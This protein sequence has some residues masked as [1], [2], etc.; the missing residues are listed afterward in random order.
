MSA[1]QAKPS[2]PIKDVFAIPELLEMILGF[3][4]MRELH[5]AQKVCKKFHDTIRASHLLQAAL[6]IEPKR[7]SHQGG[8]KFCQAIVPLRCTGMS[9]GTMDNHSKEPG[10]F[11]S[12]IYISV[13]P[14]QIPTTI[15]TR[16]DLTSLLVIQPPLRRMKVAGLHSSRWHACEEV[17]NMEGLRLRDLFSKANEHCDACSVTDREKTHIGCKSIRFEA[18]L[19][20]KSI[21]A[22]APKSN[23][24]TMQKKDIWYDAL[25]FSV[26]STC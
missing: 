14:C 1:G 5:I 12:T 25:L 10:G 17:E 15:M 2:N 20:V 13:Q 9:L 3:L 21:P 18:R 6:W 7:S 4:K 11:L 24:Q 26:T 19:S 22:P 8:G 16:P 23:R